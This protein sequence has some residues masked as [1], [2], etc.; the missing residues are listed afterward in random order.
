MSPHGQIRV[1]LV[2]PKTSFYGLLNKPSLTRLV[3][4]IS[5]EDYEGLKSDLESLAF[6]MI[7]FFMVCVYI[8][9]ILADLEEI[10]K[11]KHQ[12]RVRMRKS[13]LQIN[14]LR[15]RDHFAISPFS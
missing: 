2:S 4:E 5:N 10:R 1:L 9:K 6:Q 14:S 13:H 11:F 3:L 15:K 7:G 8:F 12:R